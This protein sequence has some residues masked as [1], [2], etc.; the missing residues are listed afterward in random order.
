MGKVV[1]WRKA[2]ERAA[3][4]ARGLTLAA[5]ANMWTPCIVGRNR[6]VGT[7]TYTLR[8]SSESRLDRQFSHTRRSCRRS[9]HAAAATTR[10]AWYVVVAP[11]YSGQAWPV[12]YSSG[13]SSF[14]CALCTLKYLAHIAQSYSF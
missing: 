5:M 7:H 10:L 1:V 13:C 2:R 3:V 12:N 9:P 4:Y 14:L 6:Y 8:L 11:I